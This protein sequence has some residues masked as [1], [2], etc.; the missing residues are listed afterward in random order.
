MDNLVMESQVLSAVEYYL[1]YKENQLFVKYFKPDQVNLKFS[2]CLLLVHWMDNRGH[3]GNSI[4][5]KIGSY[6]STTM[7]LPV[8]L[9]DIQGSGESTGNFEFPERQK[10]QIKIVYEHISITLDQEYHLTKKWTIIPVVHSISAIAVMSAIDEGLSIKSLIWIAGPPSHFKS[11]RRELSS[12]AKLGWYKFRFMAFIDTFSGII[13]LPLKTKLFGFK[14][15]VKDL[16]KGF[17]KA[18]GANMMLNHP[19]MD[20][21]A[22]F[23]SADPYLRLSD[24]DAEFPKELSKHIRR[25]IVPGA[26]HSFEMH[27]EELITTINEFINKTE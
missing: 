10:D 26:D 3:K 25:V 5:N 24:I 15:R 8:F 12:R 1:P 7:G 9:F 11:L 13:G 23:G 17:S 22:F 6:Y 4:Y 16:Y 19:E 18:N 21:L 20:I 14:F 27:V 2:T